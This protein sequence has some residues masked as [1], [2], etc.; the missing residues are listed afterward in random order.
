MLS[1]LGDNGIDIDLLTQATSQVSISCVLKDSD[2]EKG[3]RVVHES[4]F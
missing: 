2:I 1:A 3:V 4:L